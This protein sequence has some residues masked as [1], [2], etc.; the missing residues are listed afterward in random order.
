MVE[1]TEPKA[2][3]SSQSTVFNIAAVPTYVPLNLHEEG[4]YDPTTNSG[5]SQ[6]ITQNIRMYMYKI[7]QSIFRGPITVAPSTVN[8]I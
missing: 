7:D 2:D 1:K 5:E 3:Q 6:Q 4:K 8:K